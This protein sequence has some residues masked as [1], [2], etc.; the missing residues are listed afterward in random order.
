MYLPTCCNTV[1]III[2]SPSVLLHV[3][4]LGLKLQTA[5]LSGPCPLACVAWMTLPEVL[6]FAFCDPVSFHCSIWE[7]C[8]VCLCIKV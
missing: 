5:T 1:I 2:N 6:R 8:S 3:V 4:V 7:N